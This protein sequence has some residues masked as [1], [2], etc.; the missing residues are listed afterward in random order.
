[1]TVYSADWVV[2]VEGQPIPEGAVAVEDGAIVAV[3]TRAELGDGERFDGAAIVPGFVNAHTHLEYAVYAGFGDGYS[4]G[5]WLA[6]HI[7]RKS[8]IEFEQMVDIARYGAAMS[9]ASGVTTLGDASFTG[10]AAIGCSELGV[11]AIV[12]LEIF[13]ADAETARAQYARSRER[14]EEHLSPL[15][16]LGVSPHAPYSTSPEVYRAAVELGVPVMTHFNE[17]QDELD[18]LLR[19]AGPMAAASHVLLPPLGETG[20]ER[21]ARDGLLGPDWVAAHCVKVSE[22]EIELLRAA[23][24]AVAHCP[25]SNGFLGCG[26]APLA[27]LRA[28][29]LRVGV[30]TDGVSSTPSPDFF[31]ELRAVAVVARAR[32]EDA[33]AITGAEALELGTLGSARALG[34]DDRIGSLRPGKRADLAVVS[35]AGSPYHPWED[36]AAAV[37]FGGTPDRILLTVVDGNVRY[38]RGV[39][40]WQELTDAASSARRTLLALPAEASST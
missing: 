26:F 33:A 38:R 12:Y 18:W 39:T 3:G 6:T 20:I 7:E 10:A 15:V 4:F 2:P 30:G 25:R 31:E 28:A 11:R 14:V 35:L 21:L 5:P 13:G 9:L 17:S 37:A 22:G 1:L 29:G 24:V 19:G 36:P 32:Q 34:L 27:E 8:R 16:S 23:D 40:E